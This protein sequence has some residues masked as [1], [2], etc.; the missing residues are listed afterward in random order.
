MVVLSV[1]ALDVIYTSSFELS[2]P[3]VTVQVVVLSGLNSEV[4][5]THGALEFCMVPFVCPDQP[6]TVSAPEITGG[7]VAQ[8][9]SQLT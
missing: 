4:I 9:R 1:A 7:L 2:S 6:S 5:C 8:H 3:A